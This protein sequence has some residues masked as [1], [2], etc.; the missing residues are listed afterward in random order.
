MNIL[1]LITKI[2]LLVIF[3]ITLSSSTNF[4]AAQTDANNRKTY[5]PLVQNNPH[6][7][8]TE[9]KFIG[10]YME[11]YWTDAAVSTYMPIADSLTGK[12]H[13][14]SGWFINIQNIAFTARQTDN[15]TNNFYRQLEALWKYGYISFVNL[16][17]AFEASSWDVTDNCPIPFSSYQ[18]A[19]GDCDNAIIKMADLYHQWVSL[20]GG[21]RAFLAPLQEMNGV[22]AD[23]RAWTPY[24]GDPG[25]FK[26]AYQR[27]QNIFTQ[28]GVA[29][30]QVWWV[31]APNGWSKAGHE[32]EYYYPGDSVTDA[33]AFSS[34]NFGYCW[35]AMPWPYW[36]NSDVIY[37]PYINR[38][39]AMAPY[40][41][42]IIGQTGTTAEYSYT[43]EFNVSAKNT[44]LQSNY[45]YLSTQPQVLG[46]LYYDFN[47]ASY[48]CDWSITNGTTF[49]PGYQAGAGY[50][51]FQYLNWQ[52]MQSIVP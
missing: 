6:G 41:P 20:G 7:F 29:G 11:Q 8:N 9:S 36:V 37:A 32:F 2:A 16:A 26:L 34:Y 10:I 52:T 31:F 43:G 24:G 4:A 5:L 30:D 18:V 51:A 39:N 38:I 33:V 13:S 49:M 47:S 45:Q 44:W 12:K 22:N 27:I 48:E 35:V 21:R 28:M 3:V 25:N 14:V 23:G 17:S 19:H 46:M 42:I 50:S 1:K 15:R 40:K